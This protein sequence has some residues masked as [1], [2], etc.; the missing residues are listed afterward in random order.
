MTDGER[1]LYGHPYGDQARVALFGDVQPEQ[2]S[3]PVQQFPIDPPPPE[4]TPPV[5]ESKAYVYQPYPRW[6]Y[7]RSKPAVIVESAQEEIALGSGWADSPAA[8]AK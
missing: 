6:K 1:A 5:R 4:Y 8:F 3:T 2:P 7:H